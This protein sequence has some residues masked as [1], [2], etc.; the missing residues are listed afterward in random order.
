MKL[1][2]VQFFYDR[3]ENMVVCAESEEDALD[4]AAKELCNLKSDQQRCKEQASV[5]E[6]S[7]LEPSVLFWMESY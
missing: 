2:L 4:L 5:E 3:T 1:Y 7:T 6:L